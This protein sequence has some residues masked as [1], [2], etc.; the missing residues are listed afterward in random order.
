MKNVAE[1]TGKDPDGDAPTVVP[2]TSNDPTTKPVSHEP[3]EEKLP[4][5]VMPYGLGKLGS[6]LGEGIE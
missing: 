3:E 2:G 6:S 4:A 1:V 5:Y